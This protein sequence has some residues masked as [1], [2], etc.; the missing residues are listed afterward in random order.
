MALSL[1]NVKNLPDELN[2][3]NIVNNSPIIK[4][5]KEFVL[6]RCNLLII[7]VDGGKLF[8]FETIVFFY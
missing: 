4:V 7:E 6:L 2:L 5:R 8:V 1:K 3:H